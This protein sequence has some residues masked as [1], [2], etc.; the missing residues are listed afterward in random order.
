MDLQRILDHIKN[1]ISPVQPVAFPPGHFTQDAGLFEHIHITLG[2]LK[3]A[4]SIP[5]CRPRTLQIGL[6]IRKSTTSDRRTAV[7]RLASCLR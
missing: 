3:S 1:F 2:G 7:R 5:T 6:P 4:R